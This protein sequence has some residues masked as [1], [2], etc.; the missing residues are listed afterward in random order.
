MVEVRDAILRQELHLRP[1]CNRGDRRVYEGLR[2]DLRDL[3]MDGVKE[4]NV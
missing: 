2:N 4:N 1:E 3:A